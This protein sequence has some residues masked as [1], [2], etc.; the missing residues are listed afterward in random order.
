MYQK[1]SWNF[2]AEKGLKYICF[3]FLPQRACLLQYNGQNGTAG[4]YAVALT[5]ED[6]PVGTTDFNSTTPFSAVG[7][8]FLVIISARSGSCAD[9]PLFTKATPTDGECTELQIGLAYRAVIEVKLQ[10]PSRR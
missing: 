9:V 7:L 8:Q 6:F 2:L 10:D 3:N 5:L 1:Y 4:T